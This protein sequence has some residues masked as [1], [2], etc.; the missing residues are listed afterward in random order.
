MHT[1]NEGPLSNFQANNM[2]SIRLKRLVVSCIASPLLLKMGPP[3]V[4][5]F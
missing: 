2:D 5:L 4:H 1:N 3:Q